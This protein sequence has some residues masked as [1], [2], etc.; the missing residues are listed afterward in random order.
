V[1]NFC[2][3]YLYS[4]GIEQNTREIE[5]KILDKVLAKE[6]YDNK[7][8]PVGAGGT[9]TLSIEGIIIMQEQQQQQ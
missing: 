1:C 3:F 7:I 8:R 5:K 6:V 4:Q 9:G 2:V